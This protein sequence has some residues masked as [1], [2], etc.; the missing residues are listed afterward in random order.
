MYI[1]V[2][3]TRPGSSRLLEFEKKDSTG[4]NR[5]FFKKSKAGHLIETV[6]K[7]I[8]KTERSNFS[9]IVLVV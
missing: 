7:Y 2:S 5:D 6:S 3:I 8:N 1:E 4:Q 9:E